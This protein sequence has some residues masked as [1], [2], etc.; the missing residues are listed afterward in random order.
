M[1]N[2]AID[3]VKTLLHLVAKMNQ[4]SISKIEPLTSEW[5]K[6]QPL[7]EEYDLVLHLDVHP[8]QMNSLYIDMSESLQRYAEGCSILVRNF[9]INYVTFQFH[10]IKN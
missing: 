10:L 7:L 1:Y 4:V 2:A 6:D 3:N 8:S 9:I 5:S